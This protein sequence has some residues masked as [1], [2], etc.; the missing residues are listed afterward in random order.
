MTDSSSDDRPRTVSVLFVCLG[1]ICRSPLAEGVLRHRAAERGLEEA[2]DVDSAGTGAWHAGESPDERSVAVARRHGI[3]LGGQARKL[4]EADLE[5]FDWVIAMDRENLG[6]VESL[7]ERAGGSARVHLLREFDPEPG[8]EVP[9]PYFGG[10]GGF[11]D[12]YEMVDRSV[13]ALLDEI[14]DGLAGTS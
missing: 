2:I 14:E 12:V 13:T 9:D 8:E 10:P 5:E 4:T 7:R 3:E 1:N 11:D 6:N